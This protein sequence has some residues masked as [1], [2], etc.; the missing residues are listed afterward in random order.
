MILK[1]RFWNIR[2]SFVFSVLALISAISLN[3]Q[4]TERVTVSKFTLN[5]NDWGNRITL[6]QK[7]WDW[8]KGRITAGVVVNLNKN[9]EYGMYLMFFHGSVPKTENEGDFD[10]NS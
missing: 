9:N 4:N 2:L 10:K 7:Q 1:I 5:W 3:A 8:A 6:G